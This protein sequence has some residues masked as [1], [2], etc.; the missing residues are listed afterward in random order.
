M[1]PTPI[2]RQAIPCMLEVKIIKK[3]PKFT[4]YEQPENILFFYF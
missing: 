1:E 2:Q 4:V 3:D